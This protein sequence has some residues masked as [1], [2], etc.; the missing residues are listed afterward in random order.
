MGAET[1]R[2]E[3]PSTITNVATERNNPEDLLPQITF[4]AHTREALSGAVG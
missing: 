2:F 4:P 1:R 3:R